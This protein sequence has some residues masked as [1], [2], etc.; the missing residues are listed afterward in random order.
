MGCLQS[1]TGEVGPS[2]APLFC[3]GYSFKKFSLNVLSVRGGADVL[4]SAPLNWAA[5]FGELSWLSPKGIWVYSLWTEQTLGE[6][7]GEAGVEMRI[8]VC[9]KSERWSVGKTSGWLEMGQTRQRNWVC[10]RVPRTGIVY[11]IWSHSD[12]NLRTE[13][14]KPQRVTELWGNVVVL[15]VARHWGPTVQAVSGAAVCTV[16]PES[17]VPHWS[18]KREQVGAT[19]S[20]C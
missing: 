1:G 20:V 7:W 13:K 4:P 2:F 6:G 15:T 16:V 5:P 3:L 12:Q 10:R 19:G 8:F 9:R 14:S 11:R 17:G 18:S